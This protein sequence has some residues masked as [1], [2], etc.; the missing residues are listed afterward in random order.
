MSL[1]EI[2][3]QFIENIRKEMVRGL[4]DDINY[5]STV[6]CISEKE[7]LFV[8][9]SHSDG[10]AFEEVIYS[11]ELVK[12]TDILENKVREFNAKYKYVEKFETVYNKEDKLIAYRGYWYDG[13]L[14]WF[15]ESGI[16][17]AN[18]L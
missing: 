7:D 17:R 14:Y 2:T 18:K 9:I 12:L 3:K 1:E 11:T 15:Y 13:E 4:F 6:D 8:L 10:V 16:I 5:M